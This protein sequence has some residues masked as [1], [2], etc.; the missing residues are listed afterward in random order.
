MEADYQIIDTVAGL[1][2]IKK[3]FEE[4]KTIAVDLEA[5]SMYHYREKVCL[6]QIASKKTNAVI[7]PIKIKDLS[8]INRLFSS[9]K[10]KKICHGADYDIRSLYRDFR[11][12]VNNL[13][14]TETACRFIGIKETGLDAVLKRYFN[15]DINKKYQKKNWSKRPLPKEMIDYAARDVI[16]LLSLGEILTKELVKM[17]RLSWVLEEC[18][19]LSKVRPVLSNDAP[20][21]LKFK[22]AGRLESRSLAVLEALL[23]FRKRIAER[24]DVPLFKIIGNN[25]LMKITAAKPVALR[26]LEELE[27]LSKKQ[28]KMYGNDLIEVIAMALDIPEN[29]L[30]FYPRKK[31]PIISPRVAKRVWT[32][33]RWRDKKA[34]DLRLEPGLICNN[35]LISTLAI[36]NPS[37]IS[38]IDGVTTMKNWQK[39]EFGEEIITVLKNMA[40]N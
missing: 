11:I 2:R 23:Q 40:R 17:K 31:A 19:Y 20:L 8:L 28:L 18:N 22:G 38:S 37:A 39:K 9:G 7:D 26:Q 30:P 14:D 34:Q 16:Y 32:L 10:I 4:E 36:T 33:K 12:K 1:K 6:I 13:F 25:T 21:F 15:V 24:N 5:D 27:A 29:E 3:V 35:A